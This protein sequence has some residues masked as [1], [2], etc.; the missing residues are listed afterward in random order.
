M[1]FGILS[2]HYL[3]TPVIKYNHAFGIEPIQDNSGHEF[4]IGR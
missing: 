2:A 4:K 3:K 1:K